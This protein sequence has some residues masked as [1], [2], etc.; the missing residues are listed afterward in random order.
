MGEQKDLD[1]STGAQ[2]RLDEQTAFQKWLQGLNE[3]LALVAE[4]FAESLFY[5]C[6]D[7]VEVGSNEGIERALDGSEEEAMLTAADD[8]GVAVREFEVLVKFAFIIF[9]IFD[10]AAEVILDLARGGVARRVVAG[11]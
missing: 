8:C 10:E 7:V 3:V 1:S 2:G 6:E 9:K 5:L 11:V 4:T